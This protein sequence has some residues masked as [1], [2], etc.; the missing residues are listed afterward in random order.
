MALKDPQDTGCI[1]HITYQGYD[2]VFSW[3]AEL[4]FL[5]LADRGIFGTKDLPRY[6]TDTLRI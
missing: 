6:D 3:L 2:I 4:P 5:S 1:K